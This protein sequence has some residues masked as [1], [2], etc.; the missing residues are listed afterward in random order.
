[1]CMQ[2]AECRVAAG[3][4]AHR[5]YVHGGPLSCRRGRLGFPLR[6]LI[7]TILRSALLPD[8]YWKFP[9]QIW[10]FNSVLQCRERTGISQEEPD[11]EA[12]RSTYRSWVNAKCG[13]R[14]SW[15]YIIQ[16]GQAFEAD[17]VSGATPSREW[18]KIQIRSRLNFLT[19]VSP[20]YRIIV[21]LLIATK[22]SD[23]CLS[24]H[25]ETWLAW[26]AG[27][28]VTGPT[29]KTSKSKGR[30]KNLLL[31]LP[32]THHHNCTAGNLVD[33]WR[34]VANI[35]D[36]MVSLVA[37]PSL[38]TPIYDLPSYRDVASCSCYTPL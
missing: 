36:L 29:S 37:E 17:T 38:H 24:D 31:F 12:G 33:T 3:F 27:G 8:G 9:L 23:W 10:L 5:I 32:L 35:S 6:W 28:K 11:K 4:S 15:V 18:L 21:Q 26:L 34:K 1:M 19:A 2:P 7:K 25:Q 22:Q 16:G 20:S 13:G 14:P 30:H